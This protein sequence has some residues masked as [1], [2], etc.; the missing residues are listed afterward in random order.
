MSLTIICRD[1]WSLRMSQ[2]PRLAIAGIVA[3]GFLGGCAPSSAVQP[4]PGPSDYPAAEQSLSFQGALTAEVTTAYPT[5]CGAGTGPG[6][7]LFSFAAYF[8]SQG[9][10]YLIKFETDYQSRQYKGPGTYS[11]KAAIYRRAPDGPGDP[12]YSGSIQLTVSGNQGG[13]WAGSVS[14]TLDSTSSTTEKDHVNFSGGWTCTNGP[15]T[16]PG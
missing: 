8:Q 4:P 6:G 2:L 5:S 14:G 13:R 12:I 10:W 1:L 11:V 9:A 3:A 15:M 7:E 16:G